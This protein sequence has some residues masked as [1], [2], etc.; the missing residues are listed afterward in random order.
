MKQGHYQKISVSQSCILFDNL[1]QTD[2][3]SPLSLFQNTLFEKDDFKKLVTSINNALGEKKINE[4]LLN[5]SFEKWYPDLEEKVNKI[6]DTYLPDKP[7]KE[8]GDNTLNEILRTTKY[9]SNVVARFNLKLPPG[10]LDFVR[11]AEEQTLN[12]AANGNNHPIFIHVNPINDA[13]EVL[14]ELTISK[15]GMDISP[16]SGH[17]GRGVLIEILFYSEND[18]FWKLVFHFHKGDT[19]VTTNILDIPEE[20]AVLLRHETIWRD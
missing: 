9:I 5:K 15:K 3:K 2:I 14:K 4:T 16:S 18:V 11:F 20:E 7:K 17:T 1:K 10:S 6:T 13:D 12:Y 19:F 8:E